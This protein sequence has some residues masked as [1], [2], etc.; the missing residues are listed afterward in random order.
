MK[1][2]NWII[3][4]CNAVN[5]L[6]LVWHYSYVRKYLYF[7]EICIKLFKSKEVSDLQLFSERVLQQFQNSLNLE[8]YSV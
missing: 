5:L 6:I 4:L 2:V 8:N 7:Q 3:V 1:S